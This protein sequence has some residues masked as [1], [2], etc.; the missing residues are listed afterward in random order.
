MKID[1]VKDHIGEEYVTNHGS[2]YAT[3]PRHE[4]VRIDG[5]ETVTRERYRGIRSSGT[6]SKRWVRVTLLDQET[7]EP[8]TYLEDDPRPEGVEV[9]DPVTALVEAKQLDYDWASYW[10]ETEGTRAQAEAEQSAALRLNAYLPREHQAGRGG[11]RS[12]ISLTVEAANFLA[13]QLD[14]LATARQELGELS[15]DEEG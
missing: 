5:I 1:E 7:G 9:G 8:R 6:T 10:T 3:V 12:Q 4:R 14:Q 15:A 2:Y 13:D 11:W